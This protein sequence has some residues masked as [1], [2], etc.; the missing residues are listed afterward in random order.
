VISRENYKLVYAYLDDRREHGRLARNTLVQ[1]ELRLMHLLHWAGE[2]S[3]RQAPSLRPTFP[4][5][6]ASGAA[7]QDG[8][9]GLLKPEYVRKVLGAAVGF[10]RWLAK[11]RS[12]YRTSLPAWIDTL[13]SPYRFVAV[14]EPEAVTLPEVRAMARSPVYT[15]RDE[16][17]RAGAVFLFLSGMRVAAFASLPIG[18]VDLAGRTVRQWPQL[19]VRTKNRKHATTPL[20]PVSDLLEVVA[21]WDAKVRRALPLTAP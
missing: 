3:F 12:G 16:R 13:K 20:M 19:G 6:L 1:E 10:F 18:A 5:Y 9:E 11:N 14:P 4:N 7:R 21:A 15:L 17:V 8:K 2:T